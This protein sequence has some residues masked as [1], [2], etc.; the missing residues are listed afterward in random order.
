MTLTSG[1]IEGNQLDLCKCNIIF[2]HVDCFC[3]Q[4]KKED[5]A[6]SIFLLPRLRRPP[7]QSYISWIWPHF[8][9]ML[10]FVPVCLK[11]EVN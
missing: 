2:C 5:A 10:H 4:E 7:Q 8:S 9:V 1:S 3:L 6:R 11:T